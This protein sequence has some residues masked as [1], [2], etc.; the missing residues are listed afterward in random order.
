MSDIKEIRAIIRREKFDDVKNALSEIGI[1]GLNVTEVRGRGRGA[2][3]TVHG[4][5]GDYTIDL[6]PKTMVTIVLSERNLDETI[7]AI[8]KA[9]YTGEPGDGVIFVYPVDNVI[10]ISTEEE[11]HQALMY[12][13]DIDTRRRH[14]NGSK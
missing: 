2:G 9:A 13:G 7:N 11:G 10:R 3:M 5:T 6:L 8:K 4:R 12:Q 1:V 14:S